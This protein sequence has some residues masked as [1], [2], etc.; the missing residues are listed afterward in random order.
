MGAGGRGPDNPNTRVMASYNN[1]GKS[2]K[3]QNKT[4]N[5][6]DNINNSSNNNDDKSSNLDKTIVIRITI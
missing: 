5:L 2:E 3:D 4:G 1:N 6:Y